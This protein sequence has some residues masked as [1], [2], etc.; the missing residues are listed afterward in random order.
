MSN[1]PKKLKFEDLDDYQFVLDKLSK[2][3]KP[4]H[5]LLGNGFSIA[6]DH[7]IFSYNKLYDFI[8]KLEDPLLAKLFGVINTKNFEQIMRQLDMTIEIA[9]A[10]D[11]KPKFVEKLS[12]AHKTLQ[13]SLIDAVSKLHPEHVFEIAPQESKA[14]FNFL[15]KYFQK[16]GNIFST[17][18][19][20]L[21]YWVLMRNNPEISVDGF[22]KELLNPEELKRGE[23]GEWSEELYWGYN[24]QKQN[25]FYLHGA[26]PFFDTNI[27]IEKEQYTTRHYLLENIQERM[28]NHEYPIFVT[29]G[30]GDDKLAHIM[31][32]KYLT[33]CYDS[34]SNI[35]G[36]LVSFGFNFGDYD[37]HIIDAL[38]KS[39]KFNPQTGGK[40][41]SIY[42]GVY[43]EGDLEHIKGIEHKFAC[44]VNVYDSQTAKI[45]N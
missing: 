16:D 17:N 36:S 7:K 41:Y 5:L 21:L 25:I 39:T 35:N 37:E 28:Q 29:A 13:K 18:Y 30:N 38:N 19:D 1:I 42:V 34:L 31:H 22:G 10:F 11:A 44:K 4:M 14:C 43:S 6:Y 24:K 2:R 9:K 12:K 27:E 20:L 3:N 33:Y 15:D 32:N 45:W 8:D 40:L 26:L 23:E